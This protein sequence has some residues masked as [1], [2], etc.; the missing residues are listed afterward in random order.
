MSTLKEWATIDPKA[1]GTTGQPAYHVQN[2]VDGKWT[3]TRS[4]MDI[5][6]PMD[7][8]APPIFSICDTQSDEIADF[9]TSLRKVPKSGVHNPL[10]NP[11]RYLK[12]GEISRKVSFNASEDST[13]QR[14]VAH[15]V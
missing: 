7:K 9:I 2:L 14:S 5:I 12:F 10:K 1:L 13:S 11:E 15:A 6:H 3:S 4:K 8:D